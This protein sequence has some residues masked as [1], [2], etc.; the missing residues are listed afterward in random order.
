MVSRKG[1]HWHKRQQKWRVR[2]PKSV[3]GKAHHLGYY[4]GEADAAHALDR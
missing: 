4:A 3:V 1:F 2:I